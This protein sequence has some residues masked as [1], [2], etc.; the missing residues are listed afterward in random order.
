MTV[1]SVSQSATNATTS[2]STSL[3]SALGN[4]QGL[5]KNAF[6][7]LLVAQ[8]KNQDP[9]KPMDNTDFVAQLAQFSNLEQVMGIN[10]R[11]D[12]LT[13]QGQ[14]LQNTEISGLV[15][16]TVSV[17]GKNVTTDGSGAAAGFSFTLG[18]PAAQTT[19]TISDSTGNVVRTINA[20]SE[21]AGLTKMNW[22]GKND[23][24]TNQPAGTYS[25]TVAAKSS[26]NAPIPV[27]QNGT[28]VVQ[29]VSFDK[30]YPELQLDNGLAVPVSDLLEVQASPTTP[31]SP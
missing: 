18:S 5:D 27:T 11:L 4:N 28:G 23:S 21:T 7:K 17:N 9:L 14:G 2:D 24:G 22:D 8:M 29:A 31:T 1:S 13:A 19:I 26:N 20:G 25:V 3:T 30:G 15:G 6:L 10:T 16:K 12:T